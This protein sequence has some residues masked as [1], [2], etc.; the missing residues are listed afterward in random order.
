MENV[1]K[2]IQNQGLDEVDDK[3]EIELITQSINELYRQVMKLY[4][5]RRQQLRSNRSKLFGTIWS[6]CTPTLQSEITNLKEYD[7]KRKEHKCL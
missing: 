5:T 3:I 4:T 1:K 6:Q 7:E 2:E